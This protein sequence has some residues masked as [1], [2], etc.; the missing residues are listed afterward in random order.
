[1]SDLFA[2]EPIMAAAVCIAEPAPAKPQQRTVVGYDLITDAGLLRRY[3]MCVP[4]SRVGHEELVRLKFELCAAI[5]GVVA[6]Q[7]ALLEGQRGRTCLAAATELFQKGSSVLT[8]TIGSV[9]VSGFTRSLRSVGC[10]GTDTESM[11]R[12]YPAVATK[13]DMDF[14][15]VEAVELKQLLRVLK[16]H[17]HAAV[18]RAFWC[19]RR[20]TT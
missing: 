13:Q 8:L 12:S 3:D 5:E 7:M 4:A 2:T 16:H 11:L 19:F 9:A 14:L 6:A 10:C 1:M 17:V 20:V 15:S 18:L